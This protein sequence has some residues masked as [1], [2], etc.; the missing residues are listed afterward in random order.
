GGQRL[1]DLLDALL[2]RAHPGQDHL[3][4]LDR[5]GVVAAGLGQQGRGRGQDVVGRQ[6][7]LPAHRVHGGGGG[8]ASLGGEQF[9][10]VQGVGDLAAEDLGEL[11]V[12]GREGVQPRAFDVEGADYFVAHHQR[13]GERTAGA[14][15]PL[16]VVRV[17]GGVRAQVAL[18]GRRHQAGHAVALGLGVEDAA[19]GVWRHSVGQE[20]VEPAGELVEQP[21][22]DDVVVQQLVD[23]L[24]DV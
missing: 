4:L 13:N 22:F 21:D 10:R 3:E 14:G 1:A 2:D 18:A 12:L 5:L 6:G 9:E 15:G 7:D 24:T 16:N 11:K 8:A 17:V 23:E 20:R 19:G